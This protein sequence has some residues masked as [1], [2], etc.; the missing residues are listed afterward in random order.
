MGSLFDDGDNFN[1]YNSTS[2]TGY[3]T[4]FNDYPVMAHFF[5]VL[6]AQI[7]TAFGDV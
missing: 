1:G 5:T 6:I 4:H 3:D 2:G 7:R